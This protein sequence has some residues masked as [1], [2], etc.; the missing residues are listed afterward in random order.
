MAGEPEALVRDAFH[1]ALALVHLLKDT[2][3]ANPEGYVLLRTTTVSALEAMQKAAPY[4]RGLAPDW[5]PRT[6]SALEGIVWLGQRLTCLAAAAADQ[7]L[8]CDDD[9]QEAISRSWPA[10]QRFV[11]Q[12]YKPAPFGQL[13]S[14]LQREA[15]ETAERPLSPVLVLRPKD[16]GFLNVYLDVLE[17]LTANADT[18]TGTPPTIR[19]RWCDG[20]LFLGDQLVREYSREAPMQFPVLDAFESAGWPETIPRPAVCIGVKDTIQSLNDGLTSTQLRFQQ[21]FGGTRIRW[22]LDQIRSQD[23]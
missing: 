10:V 2:P 1:F 8:W 17:L 12:H 15:R 21:L 11:A 23:R 16:G 5:A 14:D 3:P 4:W 20:K 13:E 7:A 18:P 9:L 19:P 6:A 22:Y